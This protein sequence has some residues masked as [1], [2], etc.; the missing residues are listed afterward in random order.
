MLLFFNTVQPSQPTNVQVVSR[1]MTS[2]RLSWRPP[3]STVVAYYQIEYF[4][5]GPCQVPNDPSTILNISNSMI[6]ERLPRYTVTGLEEFSDY[7]FVITAANDAGM[8]SSDP[9][10]ASTVS[11]G[12]KYFNSHISLT[13]SH[14]FSSADIRSA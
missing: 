1:S 14:S 9:K 3:T 5:I 10:T 6:N 8:R 7:S 4:Y 11:A 2:I 13:C 12:M